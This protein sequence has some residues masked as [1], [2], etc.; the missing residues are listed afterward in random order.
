MNHFN[1]HFKTIAFYLVLLASYSLEAQDRR[2]EGNLILEDVPQTPKE[3][4]SRIQQYQ[5][6]RSASFADWLPND[7]GMLISTRFCNT[8][9]LHTVNSPGGARSQITFFDEPVS[10]GSF[11]PSTD[12]SGFLFTK[13]TGGN[14]FSQIYWYDTNSRTSK[15]L[16]DGASVNFGMIW[17]NTGN[18]FAFTSSRR[19]KRDFDIYG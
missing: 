17:S 10:N 15:M 12:Y 16:S 7:A 9:Q 6:T 8:S 18:K 13:D 3:I 2:E 11:C 1:F 4:T 5:T 19:N 14:E